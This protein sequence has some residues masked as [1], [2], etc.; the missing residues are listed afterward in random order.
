[1]IDRNQVHGLIRDAL[2]WG[3]AITALLAIGIGVLVSSRVTRRLARINQAAV[4]IMQGNLD[5]RVPRDDSNDDFDQLAVNLNVMLDRIQGL[6]TTI[7]EISNNVAHDLRQPLTRLTHRLEEA[8]AADS[9]AAVGMLEHATQDAEELMGTFDALLRIA[10]IESK[11]RRNKFQKVDMGTLV[12]DVGELYEPV[13]AEGSNNLKVEAEPNLTVLGD[14]N[15]LFQAVANL[16]DNAIKFTPDDGVIHLQAGYQ[17]GWVKIIVADSGPGIPLELRDK[18]FTRFF[19][20]DESRSTPGN[21][22]GLSLVHAIAELHE[23][24]IHLTDNAPG[25]RVE[26][27][28]KS[29]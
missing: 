7:Q 9:D 1:M 23:A 3:L 8:K 25:L 29:E 28:F 2:L 24:E 11:N 27:R 6:M 20:A 16:V 15:L 4:E 12:T 13:A 17:A 19:R 22:L 26:M 5:K 10:R 21:G 14:R 18:V